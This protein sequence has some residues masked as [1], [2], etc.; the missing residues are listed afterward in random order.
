MEAAPVLYQTANK[1]TIQKTNKPVLAAM[2]FLYVRDGSQMT[3]EEF[4]KLSVDTLRSTIE[5]SVTFIFAHT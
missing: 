4:M 5:T 3:Y 1:S 2:C